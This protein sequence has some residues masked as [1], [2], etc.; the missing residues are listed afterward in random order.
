VNFFIALIKGVLMKIGVIS[1]THGK[2]HPRV[3]DLFDGVD[4]ILHA[5]D[6]GKAEI[7]SELQALAPVMAVHGNVDHFPLASQYPERA[8]LSL[9]GHKILMTHIFDDRSAP[10][11]RRLLAAANAMDASI[12]IYGHTHEARIDWMDGVML[13]NPG[14]AGSPR[15]NARPSVGFLSLNEQQ[16]PSA[17]ILW[18]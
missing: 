5:G 16:P 11:M 13:F 17:E 4:H 7:I 10:A 9:E 18:L 2:M 3:F 15:F 14:S 12:I 8:M 6:I 1:D